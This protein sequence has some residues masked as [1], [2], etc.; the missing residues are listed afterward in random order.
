MKH[1]VSLILAVI[2]VTAVC[3]S[4]VTGTVA[5]FVDTETSEENYMCAGTVNLELQ[6]LNL[7]IDNL[8]PSKWYSTEKLLVNSGTLDAV[9]SVLI[10]NLENVEDAPGAGVATTQPELVAEEGGKI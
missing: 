8:M 2:L 10:K 7:V 4:V 1:L 6:G 9:A 3:G 5:D